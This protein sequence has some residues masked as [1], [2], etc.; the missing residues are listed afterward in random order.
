MVRNQ[1]TKRFLYLMTRGMLDGCTAY[2]FMSK[3]TMESVKF[4]KDHLYS[5][6][7]VHAF[8][9]KEGI[10]FNFRTASMHQV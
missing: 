9:G 10:N 3:D 5:C 1:Q 4:Q 7:D 2:C 6:Q 8:R